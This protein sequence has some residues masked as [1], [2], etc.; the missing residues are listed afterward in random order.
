MDASAPQPDAHAI[1]FAPDGPP[2]GLFADGREAPP[3]PLPVLGALPD[4]LSGALFLNGPGRFAGLRHLFD[5]YA[6]LHKFSLGAGGAAYTARFLQS[7]SFRAASAA[8]GAPQAR[9]FA[10]SPGGLAGRLRTLAAGSRASDNANVTLVPLR[11]ALYALTEAPLAWRVRKADVAT[12]GAWGGAP[13]ASRAS[14]AE[15]AATVCAHALRHPGLPGLFDGRPFAALLSSRFALW[16]G[17]YALSLVADDGGPRASA[18]RALAPPFGSRPAY[19]HSFALTRARAVVTE[20]PMRLSARAMLRVLALAPDGTPITDGFPWDARGAVAFRVLD[21]A[22]GRDEGT[23][24]LPNGTPPFFV[25]HHVNAWDDGAADGGGLFVDVCAHEGGPGVLREFELAR[26]RTRVRAAPGARARYRRFHLDPARGAA[27]EVTL[28]E[29]LL[30]DAPSDAGASF[31]LP[32]VAP[33]VAGERHRFVY[34]ARASAAAPFVDA[35][36]KIDTAEGGMTRAWAQRGCAPHEPVFVPRPGGA[37]EDDGVVLAVVCAPTAAAARGD[38]GTGGGMKK[39]AGA[40]ESAGASFLLVLDAARFEEV[41]R[42][43]LEWALPYTFHGAWLA[44]SDAEEE[45]EGFD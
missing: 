43:P 14:A 15:V 40:E 19:V 11:G 13:F 7:D 29:G 42:C 17:S 2:S 38:V 6:L 16:G 44:G 34:A 10:S 24:R 30:G 12:A 37:Q 27:R 26:L 35:L 23:C 41:A 32:S 3:A 4:W 45:G 20:A 36:V 25:L 1:P 21:L 5:G 18:A 9:E 28:R 39:G 31:E 22:S 33:A 8:G